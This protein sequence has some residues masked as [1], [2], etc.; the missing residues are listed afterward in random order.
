MNRCRCLLAVCL[1][2]LLMPAVS[3]AFGFNDVIHK[4]KTLAGKPYKAPATIPQFMQNL[5]NEQ[6]QGIRFKAENSLWAPANSRFQVEMVSP[7]MFYKHAVKIH[8]V[9][10]QGVRDITYN[11]SD[12]NFANE[13]L[14]R[15]IPA[16][17]GYAGFKLT[18][19]MGNGKRKPILSFAGASY[20]QAIGL[21]NVFGLSA[22]GVA[23][24]TGLPS[25][26]QFPSF[27]EF[28]LV[29]PDAHDHV[30][31][32][33]ALLN[34]KSLTGA[35]RFEVRAGNTT[36]INVQARLFVRNDIQMLG[37]APLTSMFFYGAN[38]G[39][40]TGEWRPQVHD[41]DGLLVHNGGTGEWLWRPLLD[42]KTLKLDYFHTDN[43]QGFGLLQRQNEFVDYSDNNA[44]YQD[45]PSAWVEPKG[46]WGKGRVVLV[47][48]PTNNESNDNITSFW[49]PD[50][51][52]KKGDSLSYDYDLKFGGRDIPGSQLGQAV[53]TFVGDGNKMGGGSAPGA[54]RIIVDFAGG[55]LNGLAPDAPVISNVS[56][57]DGGKILEH[58][59]EYL[60]QTRRWRM[61]IL[62]KPADG[63]P[64]RL[65]AFLKKGDDTVSETW[66]YEIPVNN[67]ILGEAR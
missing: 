16:D 55:A 66:S 21:D 13:D 65:R 63:Q 25:G 29:R 34:G 45:R 33:Y 46:N 30:A 20:F 44:N 11:K 49:T 19:P 32:I 48:L 15:R 51:A 10:A 12:F 27:R 3:Q 28:W 35:Y 6:Y 14:G 8:V 40:P 54:Y 60:P 31:V 52:V 38:T 58:F 62:A 59:V 47:Q 56:A 41:S 4:A 18:Y 61:S 23:V 1:V 17:L 57:D 5:S 53:K 9:N 22:R 24:D 26:E 37:I 2:S 7:G 42:P 50:Q 36:V 64:L 39:R 43:V 67:D